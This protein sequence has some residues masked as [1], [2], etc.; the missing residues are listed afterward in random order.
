[1][2]I[3]IR[4][5]GSA[6]TVAARVAAMTGVELGACFQCRRC[7]SGCP[8]ASMTGSTPSEIMRRLHLG[9]G[10]ELLDDGFIWV[11]ASCGTC[12]ARCP[13]GLDIA[14][15][16]DALR[17]LSLERGVSAP[18][19]NPPLFN[20]MF[21]RTVEIFGRSYDLGMIAGYKLGSMKLFADAEKFPTMLAK[22]KIAL[23]PPGGSSPGVVK[24]IFQRIRNRRRKEGGGL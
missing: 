8:V 19:G 24:R 3:Q 9:A 17:E 22:G 16:I 5:D 18:V 4:K 23:T 20:R 2:T 15:V 21:L 6:G 12:S 10:D 1:M 7:T 11:C 13:M 14:K